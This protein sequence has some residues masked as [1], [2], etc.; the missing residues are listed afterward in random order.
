[1][2][3]HGVLIIII[4]PV[5]ILLLVVPVDVP[6]GRIE[7]MTERFNSESKGE[8]LLNCLIAFLVFC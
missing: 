6:L 5:S 8:L 4:M 2:T 1:M 3:P 7:R